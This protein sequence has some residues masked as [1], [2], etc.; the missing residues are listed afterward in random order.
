MKAAVLREFGTP[1]FE[2]F[3]EPQ[4]QPGYE[5]L[6]VLAASLNA[7]DRAI[8]AGAHY[9]S[10]KE[11]PVI[12]GIEGVG[13]R[14]TGERV[15]FGRPETPYGSMAERTLVNEHY[16]M[17]IP[18]DLDDAIA[19]TI[20]NAGWAAW[21]P[22]S[23]RAALAPGE[24]V[25]ILGA[26]G[27]VGRLAV[28]AA[29]LL[30]AGHVV[31]AGRD[32]E[33]LEAVR[34]L[35]ADATVRLDDG[36]PTDAFLAAGGPYDIIV[37]YTWGAPA[38]AAL[39]AGAN[40]VRLVHVGERAGAELNVSGQ[41]IRSKGASIFGFMPI[42]AAPAIVG[43]AYLEMA[44]QVLAGRLIVDVE[45]VPLS[46]VGEAWHRQSRRKI[47]LT[48]CGLPHDASALGLAHWSSR[49]VTTRRRQE[50]SPSGRWRRS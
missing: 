3:P 25:L 22:L 40:G 5:V 44:A 33:A 49:C 24:S 17:A 42:H 43:A 11:L 29:K 32:P 45:R 50:G 19:A 38:G 12:S 20:G 26:T 4:P 7:V 23:W 34:A 21:L 46:A 35:G 27:V 13:R 1:T 28:Q 14:A 2:D 31:A 48:P 15:Y 41:V 36:D 30:G 9:L 6:D 18:D 47:V 8:A 37:D 39:R 16:M 10:P